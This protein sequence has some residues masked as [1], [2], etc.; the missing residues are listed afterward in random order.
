M[1]GPAGVQYA[2]TARKPALSKSAVA[3]LDAARACAACYLVFHHV[4][5]AHAVAPRLGLI[6]RFGQEAVLIFFLLSGFVIFANEHERARHPRG[7]YL[8]RLRRIYPPLLC[9]MILSTA[10]A[11]ANGDFHARFHWS[12]LWGT[13]LSVQDI[14]FLKP[15]VIVDP[16]LGNAPLWS[17]SYEVAF[18]LVFPAVLLLWRNARWAASHVVGTVCCVLYIWFALEPSHFALVG[19]YFLVWWC[20]AMSAEA[21]LHGGRSVTA[22]LDSYIWLLL[23]CFIA[24]VVVLKV[25]YTQLG[26]YPFLPLRH[27]A[28]AALLLAVFFGPIGRLGA[29]VA[30]RCRGAFAPIAIDILR[31]VRPALS[32]ARS[33][34]A[35]VEQRSWTGSVGALAFDPGLPRR[36]SAGEGPEAGASY[37][38]VGQ[39]SMS[40]VRR[41]I[42]TLI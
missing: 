42:G 9:A 29:R 1:A 33:M 40:F 20:G 12:E 24:A 25:G 11:M 2:Q 13:L 32:T 5:E 28:V 37:R 38:V 8:R 31:A 16:Y 30:H 19:A 17:L 26:R 7:Y 27:F 36:A 3:A 35:R 34:E 22:M 10:V 41:K 14:A 21:Y 18:Y 15:G 4:M 6:F 23:L 39:F